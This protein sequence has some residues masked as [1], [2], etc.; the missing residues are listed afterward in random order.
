MKLL[1]VIPHMRIGGAQRLVSDMLPVMAAADP[2][3]EIMLVVYEDN[4]DSVLMRTVTDC[5]RIKVKYLGMSLHEHIRIIRALRG[6]LREADVCHVHLFPALYHVAV[7]SLGVPTPVVYTEHNTHNR[8]RNHKLLKIAEKWI[9][10]RYSAIA[11]IGDAVAYNLERWIGVKNVTVIRNGIDRKRF[12]SFEAGN[13]REVFGRDGKPILMIS[14]FVESKDQAALIRAMRE[15]KTPGA[16]AAF[17]GSGPFL[18]ECGQL[19][20]ECGVEDRVVFL[21]DRSDVARLV[22]TASIGVQMSHWEGFGL[23]VIE[24]MA[25]GLPVIASEVSGLD[26]VV[27]GAGVLVPP[28]DYHRLAVEIDKMLTEIDSKPCH[29]EFERMLAESEARALKYDIGNTV[30]GYLDIYRR[31]SSL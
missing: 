4:A 23:T 19:A 1:T 28:S 16:F 31:V 8:R 17:A 29:A 13:V 2:D 30:S 18:E 20:R 24:M 9:Y 3:L 26:D 15:V 14:R 12:S 7:A 11:G 6:Y 5:P 25:G 22:S 27:R 10:S 21:G